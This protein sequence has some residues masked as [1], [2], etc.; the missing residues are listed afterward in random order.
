MD[1]GATLREAR[2]QAG[3]S[4]QEV[5]QRTKIQLAKIEALE[6]NAFERLPEGIYLDGLIRA[7]AVEVGLDGSELVAAFRR[8]AQLRPPVEQTPAAHVGPVDD[9]EMRAFDDTDYL[10][11]PA[12]TPQ[13]PAGAVPLD[14]TY[15]PE[16]AYSASHVSSAP[17]FGMAA[18]PS[19]RRSLGGVLLPILALI[20]A[21]GAGAYLYG[22]TRPFTAREDIRTPAVSH[23]NAELSARETDN[24]AV[25]T[26][27]ETLPAERPGKDARAADGATPSPNATSHHAPKPLEPPTPI[28][29]PSR[30]PLRSGA[31]SASAEPGVPTSRS[32]V[33]SPTSD[34]AVSP[35]ASPTSPA[36]AGAPGDLAGFWTL[37]TRV[38]SSSL[39]QYEGLQLGYRVQ[40][41]Q[42]GNRI[43]GEGVKTLEN[44]Q[45]LG[46]TAQTPIAVQGTLDGKRLTLTF[47]ERGRQ[48]ESG[49]KMILE[50]NEDGVLR[51]R[52]SSSAARSAG[53]VEARRPEG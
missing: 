5:S 48:R 17:T 42:S 10:V 19:P 11:R 40:L 31:A 14:S 28:P 33:P 8:D 50:L 32:S 44:G 15:E 13:Q 46:E 7:Y 34:E 18:E 1:V 12:S 47:V 51:G 45:T 23:E 27:R 39:S 2:Q 43:T 49:G 52:F 3:L 21:I 38:E 4:S 9:A 53:T 29:D 16:F 25:R 30:T 26:S 36:S 35:D 22:R 20:V 37:D 41:Q 24:D 6:A